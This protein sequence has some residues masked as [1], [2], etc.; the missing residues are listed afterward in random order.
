MIPVGDSNRIKVGLL[1]QWSL[2]A[3]FNL[4]KYDHAGI[5]SMHVK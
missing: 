3:E 2:R 5:D 1:S 4:D